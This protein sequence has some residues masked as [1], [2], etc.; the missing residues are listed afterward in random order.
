[1]ERDS[2]RLSNELATA[3]DQGAQSERGRQLNAELGRLQDQLR[4]A[5]QDLL[6]S[7]DER[8]RQQTGLQGAQTELAA[9]RSSVITAQPGLVPAAYTCPVPA[10]TVP[11][12]APPGQTSPRSNAASTHG[13]GP[14]SS[15]FTPLAT[16]SATP[17]PG[18]S[19]TQQTWPGSALGQAA[20]SAAME[21][22]KQWRQDVL[23]R[24]LARWEECGRCWLQSLTW[25]SAVLPSPHPT[26]AFSAVC[27]HC[28]SSWRMWT[29]MTVV[30]QRTISQSRWI[31][32]AQ[33]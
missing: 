11:A 17:V 14:S 2:T 12:V 18:L 15:G 6:N 23:H 22:S 25:S 13:S 19:V 20:A 28:A 16:P 9:L 1:M 27:Q 7:E 33:R 26:P 3:K 21:T 24:E 29:V 5:K 30:G 31:L 32:E 4:Y 8:K 10:E